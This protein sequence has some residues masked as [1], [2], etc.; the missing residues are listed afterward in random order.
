MLDQFRSDLATRDVHIPVLIVH[1]DADPVIPI[2]L[3]R[4]LFE[5]TSEPKTFIR[6]AGGGHLVLGSPEAFPRVREWIDATTAGIA[7]PPGHNRS[8]PE[9]ICR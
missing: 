9:T 3:A 1:G 7:C 2:D 8:A 6:V 4:R 5:Y